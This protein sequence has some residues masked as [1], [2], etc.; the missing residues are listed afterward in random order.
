MGLEQ[1]ARPGMARSAIE[2]MEVLAMSYCKG[3]LQDPIGRNQ[4]GSSRS[5]LHTTKITRT[6]GVK[7]VF[8]LVR[9]RQNAPTNPASVRVAQ[10]E[11]NKAPGNELTF[12]SE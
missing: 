9:G 11:S 10:R 5:E 3:S 2:H 4:K 7:S 6:A 12:N 1:R 8:F